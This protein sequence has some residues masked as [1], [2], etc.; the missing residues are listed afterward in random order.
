MAEPSMAND[1]RG[2]QLSG[3]SSADRM[4]S[5]ARGTLEG[6]CSPF[7]AQLPSI[8]LAAEIWIWWSAFPVEFSRPAILGWPSDWPSDA[9]AQSVTPRVGWIPTPPFGKQLSGARNKAAPLPRLW[10][11][12]GLSDQEAGRRWLRSADPPRPA[13]PRPLHNDPRPPPC[14][15]NLRTLR[16]P[17]LWLS[18]WCLSPSVVCY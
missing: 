8:Y 6:G 1:T 4:R 2:G 3:I 11:A 16:L 12:W 5:F 17:R 14:D 18:R 15:R 10:L 7:S 13:H 9:G